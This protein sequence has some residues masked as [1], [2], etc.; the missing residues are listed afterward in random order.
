MSE[1]ERIEAFLKEVNAV[2]E[3]YNMWFVSSILYKGVCIFDNAML[4]TV[5][6]EVEADNDGYFCKEVERFD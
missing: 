1:H 6:E 2:S 5:A 3:K 4:R